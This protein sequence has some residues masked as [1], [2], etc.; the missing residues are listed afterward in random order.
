MVNRL[1]E[2]ETGAPFPLTRPGLGLYAVEIKL[3]VGHRLLFRSNECDVG[4]LILRSRVGGGVGGV[5]T[6]QIA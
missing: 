5:A 2:S 4:P 6:G 1:P 3:S